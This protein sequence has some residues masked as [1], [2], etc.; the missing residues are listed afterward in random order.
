MNVSHIWFIS[1]KTIGS[2]IE[3][4]LN[5]RRHKENKNIP[6]SSLVAFFIRLFVEQNSKPFVYDLVGWPG[7][8]RYLHTRCHTWTFLSCLYLRNIL[9]RFFL[10]NENEFRPLQSVHIPYWIDL[11]VH[12]PLSRQPTC[13]HPGI[14]QILQRTCSHLGIVRT[15]VSSCS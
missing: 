5:A 10:D 7:P 8:V 2:I 11:S 15:I 12:I 6:N 1:R 14:H 9:D 13:S 3:R 4:Q